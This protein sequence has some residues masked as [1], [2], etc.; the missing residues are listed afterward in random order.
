MNSL[1]KAYRVRI[2]AICQK[3]VSFCV[4][5]DPDDLL[6][7]VRA[8]YTI[9]C[10]SVIALIPLERSDCI[11]PGLS[12]QIQL[13]AVIAQIAETTKESLEEQGRFAC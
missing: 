13:P 11:R 6:P 8:G 4:S 1:L 9:L 12:V 7:R 5:L 10:Q 2:Y 3:R